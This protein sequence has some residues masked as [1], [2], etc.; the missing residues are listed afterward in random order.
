MPRN[1]AHCFRYPRRD[2]SVGS[3]AIQLANKVANLKV[4]AT[5]SRPESAQWC[6][7]LG[8]HHVVNHFGNIAAEVRALGIKYSTGDVR[9]GTIDAA[10]LLTSTFQ[11][12]TGSAA[13]KVAPP[14]LPRQSSRPLPRP[15]LSA[16][17]R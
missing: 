10:K 9:D 5:A 11:G 15:P 7:D 8:A 2:A 16:R 17:P 3:I 6:R 12:R 4:I 14:G 13:Q 1:M